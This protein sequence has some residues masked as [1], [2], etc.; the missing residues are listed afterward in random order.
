MKR[1]EN[2]IKGGKKQYPNTDEMVLSIGACGAMLNDMA[3]KLEEQDKLINMALEST[4]KT[5]N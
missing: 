5:V 2:Y 1:F 3:E 4:E